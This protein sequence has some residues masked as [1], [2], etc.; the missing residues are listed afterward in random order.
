[1][2]FSS[3]VGM[4]D[5]SAS[6]NLLEQKPEGVVFQ[7]H[8]LKIVSAFLFSMVSDK[9]SFRLSNGAWKILLTDFIDDGRKPDA[10]GHA[11]MRRADLLFWHG[12]AVDGIGVG[13]LW[14]GG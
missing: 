11:V 4:V 8:A 9:V 5:V 3:G 7:D 14:L 12:Q 10:I 6:L 13:G 1:M 2:S